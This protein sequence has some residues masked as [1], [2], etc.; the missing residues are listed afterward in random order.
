MYL[1]FT[2]TQQANLD[3]YSWSRELNAVYFDLSRMS[4]AFAM[5]LF[6]FFSIIHDSYDK[7]TQNREFLNMEM[8]QE[9]MALWQYEEMSPIMNVF[10]RILYSVYLVAPIIMMCFN[11]YEDGGVFMT[12]VGNSYIGMGHVFVCIMVCMFVYMFVEYPMDRLIRVT[13]SD[14]YISHDGMVSKAF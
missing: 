9:G 2:V 1:N 7:G 12:M 5:M 13:I 11:D 10:G 4:W 14:K 8:G 6:A 3:P